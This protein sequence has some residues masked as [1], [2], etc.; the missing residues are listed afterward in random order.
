MHIIVQQQ[1][2]GRF[3]ITINDSGERRE[4][5]NV[6]HDLTKPHSLEISSI[7]CHVLSFTHTA[8]YCWLKAGMP[9]HSTT[10]QG[11]DHNSTKVA[12]FRASRSLPFDTRCLRIIIAWSSYSGEAKSSAI[13]P[14]GHEVCNFLSKSPT[15]KVS[16]IRLDVS[17]SDS[18]NKLRKNKV[19]VDVPL[20]LLPIG[21]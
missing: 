16:P 21:R 14:A 4:M 18:R 15:C 17:G 13:T 7:W 2:H 3:V 6:P 20:R 12:F 10:K 1:R 5:A 11:E 9:I 8:G 19:T